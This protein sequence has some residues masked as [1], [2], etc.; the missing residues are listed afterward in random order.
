M[1]SRTIW[2]SN[3][4][5]RCAGQ[6]GAH[7]S[8]SGQAEVEKLTT[9]LPSQAAVMANPAESLFQ[10]GPSTPDHPATNIDRRNR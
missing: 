6:Q 5:A 10:Q 1:S 4:I 3:C 8:V 2:N 9:D 7:P